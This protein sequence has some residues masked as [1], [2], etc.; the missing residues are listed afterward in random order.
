MFGETFLG[1]FLGSA[2]VA[3][4]VTYFFDKKKIRFSW[5][6]EEQAKAITELYS[7]MAELHAM[8]T[9]MSD[10][11]TT[12]SE[13][14][15]AKKA[16]RLKKMETASNLYNDCYLYFTKNKIFFTKNSSD[17]DF[18]MRNGKAAYEKY[19]Q[20]SQPLLDGHNAGDRE[21][22]EL[23]VIDAREEC[24][25]MESKLDVLLNNFVGILEGTPPK[26]T[27]TP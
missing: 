14:D 19:V 24:Q 17:I 8:L 1:A 9:E 21:C 13:D 25:K 23:R 12:E 5:W 22:C 6:H 26:R 20:K 16:S 4:C 18:F 7:K 10:R 27:P 11:C 15:A 3:G 2:V